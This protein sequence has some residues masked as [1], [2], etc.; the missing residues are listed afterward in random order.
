METI[1]IKRKVKSSTLKIKELEKF[2]DKDVLISITPV[3]HKTKFSPKSINKEQLNQD[4]LSI[5]Q[6]DLYE[7]DIKVKSWKIADY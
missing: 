1:R 6:W 4:I 5:S 2:K 3:F 7:K